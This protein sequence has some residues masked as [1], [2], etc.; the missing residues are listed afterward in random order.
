MKHTERG[1]GR[2]GLLYNRG[3][4]WPSYKSCSAAWDED[5]SGKTE[6]WLQELSILVEKEEREVYGMEWAS[7]GKR[8]KMERR[9]PT[10]CA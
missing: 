6:S 3:D 4:R 7:M 10:G 9:H 2:I 5:C 8:G 1:K